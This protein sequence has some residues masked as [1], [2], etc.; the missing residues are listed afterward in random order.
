MDPAGA[1]AGGSAF[2]GL[3]PP[4][5]RFRRTL[6]TLFRKPL[7]NEGSET[8]Q[9]RDVSSAKRGVLKPLIFGTAYACFPGSGP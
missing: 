6:G 9:N 5:G 7:K 8:Q 2:V 1:L 4:D 3:L